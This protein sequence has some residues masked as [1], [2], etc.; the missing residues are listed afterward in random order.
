M[1]TKYILTQRR[2]RGE[3]EVLL[4]A[5]QEE[6]EGA[7]RIE[8]V[9]ATEGTMEENLVHTRKIGT[10]SITLTISNT[11]AM[12]GSHRPQGQ[13]EEAQ[14][15]LATLEGIGSKTQDMDI[16]PEGMNL[17]EEGMMTTDRKEIIGVTEAL[18]E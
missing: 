11:R 15:Q 2:V 9:R 5:T 6:E 4:G 12:I 17:E 16:A 14:G 3:Q 13:E 1:I 7:M 10:M 18:A 8:G